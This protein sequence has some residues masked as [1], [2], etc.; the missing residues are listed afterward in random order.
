[1][2]HLVCPQC[3]TTAFM[4]ASRGGCPNCGFALA[5]SLERRWTWRGRLF[6]LVAALGLLFWFGSALFLPSAVAGVLG[7]PATVLGLGTFFLGLAGAAVSAMRSMTYHRFYDPTL[8]W[9]DD[10]G[11]GSARTVSDVRDRRRQ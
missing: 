6:L 10:R 9:N 1:M 3:G 5:R 7:P 4:G 8:V 11:R 2:Q